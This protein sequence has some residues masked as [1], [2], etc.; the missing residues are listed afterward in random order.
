MKQKTVKSAKKRVVK[1]TKSGKLLRRK[2]SAQHLAAGKSKRTLRAS[3]KKTAIASS[4][5]KKM[6]RMIPNK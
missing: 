6:K 3:N 5:V 1:V 2:I 4:D